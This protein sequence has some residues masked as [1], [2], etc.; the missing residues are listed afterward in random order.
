MI[1]LENESLSKHT[2]IRIGGICKSYY[3][4]E[5]IDEIIKITKI[6]DDVKCIGGGSNLLINDRVFEE[7]YDLIRFDQTIEDLGGGYFQVGAS[8]RL[9]KLINVVNECGYGGIE[10]LFSIPGTVG[11][12]VAM[13]AGRGESYN[14]SISDYVV[15]LCAVKRGTVYDINRDECGFEYRDS[16]FKKSNMIISSVTFRFPEMT[17]DVVS[18]AKQ[19]RME[20]VKRVQDNSNPN[21]GSVFSKCD[22][23]I[24]KFAKFLKIGKR[25]HFSGKTENWIVNE[26]GNFKDVISSMVSVER[27]HKILGKEIKREVVVW[28]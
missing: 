6:K 23:R 17:F 5:N 11:G 13:N 19:K 4:P 20:L 22:H 15:S 24:M 8:V 2:T 10:Y 9:Q 1:I 7:V 14:Q 25:A 26:D 21:F 28:E 12:A 3:I 18:D 27:I 16:V